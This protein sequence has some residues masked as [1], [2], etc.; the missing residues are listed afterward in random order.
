LCVV[1]TGKRVGKRRKLLIY[2]VLMK[3]E[4]AS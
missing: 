2:H 4:S 3:A 1:E